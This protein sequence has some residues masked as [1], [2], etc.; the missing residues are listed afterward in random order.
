MNIEN[1]FIAHRMPLFFPVF[2]VTV[3]YSHICG[4]HLQRFRD[5]RL[6]LY[7]R[8]C[9]SEFSV[10]GTT[11]DSELSEDDADVGESLSEIIP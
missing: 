5:L 2:Q 8:T 7:L 3:E 11:L 6:Y 1:Y 10:Q 4:R 9:N